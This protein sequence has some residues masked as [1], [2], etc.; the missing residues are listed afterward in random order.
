M[1]SVL[2]FYICLFL[3]QKDVTS[4]RLIE[5]RVPAHVAEG[6]DVLLGCAF[7]LENDILYSVKWYKDNYEFYRYLGF[8]NHAVTYYTR[9]IQVD[10]TR[11]S[12][13]T[14]WLKNV[15]SSASGTYICEVQGEAPGFATVSESKQ[16]SVHLLP[17]NEPV[18]TGGKDT[19]KVGDIVN[20]NCTSAA[21][22]PKTQLRW[23]INDEVANPEYLIGPYVISSLSRVD[24]FVT[25]LGLNFQVMSKH[26]RRGVMKLKCD[27][28]IAPMYNDQTVVKVNTPIETTSEE[29]ISN[30]LEDN[31]DEWPSL[32]K[33]NHIFYDPDD[34]DDR[35]ERSIEMPSTAI[36]SCLNTFLTTIV[37]V[38]VFGFYV[39]FE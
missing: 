35:G 39:F 23:W 12:I 32:G 5:L 20:L 18:I 28:T 25:E 22:R 27:A 34:Y 9:G 4:L 13:D 33:H 19:Y 36:G 8:E 24:A 14:V 30:S 1:K 10:V 16:I 17:E 38:R 15:S 37:L 11:S 21:S 7:D 29:V 6:S 2:L 31:D 3:V 26:F